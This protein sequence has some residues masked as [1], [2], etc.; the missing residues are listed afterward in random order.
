MKK[1]L[2]FVLILCCLSCESN[3]SPD[4]CDIVN[5]TTVNLVNPQFINLLSPAGWAYAN[6]GP[7]GLILYNTGTSFKA[8]S[9]EC[10]QRNGCTQRLEVKNDIK[11]SMTN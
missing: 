8:F 2:A 1:L 11:L 4:F 5:P 3:D 6:G 9:R 10:P 7:R